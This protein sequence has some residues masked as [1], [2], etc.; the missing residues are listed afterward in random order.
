MENKFE[1]QIFRFGSG[2]VAELNE[3]KLLVKADNGASTI[4]SKN[5]DNFKYLDFVKVRLSPFGLIARTVGIGFLLLLF[6][7]SEVKAATFQSNIIQSLMFYAAIILFI[8]A[9]LAFFA[10]IL[11]S[12]LEFHLYERLVMNYFA[13]RGY[14]V[15]VGNKSGNNIVFF[16]LENELNKVKKMEGA[17]NDLKIHLETK[18]TQQVTPIA[19]NQNNTSDAM[20]DNLKKLGELYQTGILT[21]EEFEQKKTELLNK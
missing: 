11:D 21:K 14:A 17:I 20:L 8:I 15:T 1:L 3:E 7:G 6:C 18:Q 12:F 4:E 2:V 9:V 10:L 5:L 16:A 19:N 13:N